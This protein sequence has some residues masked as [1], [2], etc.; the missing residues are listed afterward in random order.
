MNRQTLIK[1]NLEYLELLKLCE[2]IVIKEDLY[3]IRSEIEDI[4]AEA[5]HKRGYVPGFYKSYA[6]YNG[7]T[8]IEELENE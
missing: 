7:Y 4:F 1:Q 2:S 6:E 3:P 8:T 5:Q